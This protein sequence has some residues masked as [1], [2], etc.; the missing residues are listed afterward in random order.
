RV[1]GAH[2]GTGKQRIDPDE[3]DAD[4][5]GD[6]MHARQALAHDLAGEPAALLRTRAGIAHARLALEAAVEADGDLELVGPRAAGGIRHRDPVGAG[7]G[8]AYLAEVGRDIRRQIAR[9]VVYLVK[10]LLFD[11]RHAH[12]A[13]GLGKLADDGAAVSRHF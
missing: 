3:I 2:P 5:A 9:G 6:A 7:G 1:G 13:P 8:D 12:A 10:Q 11:G 4:I